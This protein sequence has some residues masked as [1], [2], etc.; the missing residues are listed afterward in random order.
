MPGDP[1]FEPVRLGTALGRGVLIAT[2]LGS[3]ISFLDGLVINVALPRM[4]RELHLG[5]TGLQWAV[6]GFL[7]SISAFLLLGGSLGDLYGRRRIYLIGLGIFVCASMGCGLAPNAETIVIARIVQG[8]GGALMVPASLAIIQ[9]VFVPDDRGAA[10]GAWTG[11]SA[12]F[13]AIGPFVGGVFVTYISWRWAFFINVPLGALAWFATLR[14]V[15]EN[16]EADEIGKRPDLGGALLAAFGLA[17]VTF[18]S[19][20]GTS[21]IYGQWPLILGVTGIAVLVAFV[22]Y[23]SRVKNPMLPL[24]LFRSAQFNWVN[25]CTVIFYGAFVGGLTF[26]G[27]QLQTNLNYSPLE[28]SLATFP[29]S[30]LMFTLSKR[31][32]AWGHRVGAKYPMAIGPALV[33]V[34]LF[35]MGGIQ[36][37]R[38]YWTYVLPCVLLWGLGLSMTVAPLTAAAL[39]AVDPRYLGVGS[40]FNN[41][42]SRVGQSLAISLF[43]AIVGIA[44]D[45]SLG[46]HE[47]AEGFRHLMYLAS[48]LC[49]LAAAIALL[50]V[51]GRTAKAPV[52]AETSSVAG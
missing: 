29:T 22:F 39:A 49:L 6:S 1:E 11:L 45:K 36:P 47:F 24:V 42:A 14:W 23:E 12:V 31:F 2:V 19:I 40:A 5:V 44:G 10:I 46:G 7:L 52:A 4:D 20:E 51:T 35:A 18:W 13:T 33:A 8:I 30:I 50:F 34:A 9:A 16:R 27:V 3:G 37:G 28:A 43:P 21:N 32:G 25:V 26:L 48:G 17:G 41:A 15:P 38:S